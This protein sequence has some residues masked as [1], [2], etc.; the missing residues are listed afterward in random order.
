[1][2]TLVKQMF[3]I[4]IHD[5]DDLIRVLDVLLETNRITK[6]DI[7]KYCMVYYKQYVFKKY[8]DK[9]CLEN[10]KINVESIITIC[11]IVYPA[12]FSYIID[13]YDININTVDRNDNTLLS[14]VVQHNIYSNQLIRN[15]LKKGCNPNYRNRNNKTPLDYAIS[16]RNTDIIRELLPITNLSLEDRIGLIERASIIPSNI[17]FSV[18]NINWCEA[19]KI[20][21]VGTYQILLDL[22]DDSSDICKKELLG[23]IIGRED[24]YLRYLDVLLNIKKISIENSH[25]TEDIWTLETIE[26]EEIIQYGKDINGKYKTLTIK[27]VLEI[28]RQTS[29]YVSLGYIKDPFD[30]SS[31]TEE[32]SYPN[33]YPFFIEILI[34]RLVI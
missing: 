13:N 26:D 6:L 10:V 11:C 23:H 21:K 12:L 28:V 1:M 5:E 25:N 7:I 22:I 4:Y 33:G 8:I 16:H 3:F 29:D 18:F 15:L 14:L 34:R 27:S 9:E 31:L 20:M 2:N 24:G 32:L 17:L 19:I 30:R